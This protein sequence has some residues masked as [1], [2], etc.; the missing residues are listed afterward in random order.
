MTVLLGGIAYSP[1]IQSA[2]DFY[3]LSPTACAFT[4]DFG[5]SPSGFIIDGYK[6]HATDTGYV[7]R[8]GLSVNN[9][10]TTVTTWGIN[11]GHKAPS[12]LQDYYYRIH[13]SITALALGNVLSEQIF[14]VEIWNSWFVDD[15]LSDIGV[16]NLPDVNLTLPFATPKTFNP[17]EVITGTITVVTSGTPIIDGSYTLTFA[18]ESLSLPVIG[19]RIVVWPFSPAAQHTEQRQWLTDVLPAKQGETRYAMRD[20]ARTTLNYSYNFHSREDYTQARTLAKDV[21]NLALGL[22]LWTEVAKSINISAGA[23]TIYFDTTYL[24]LSINDPIILWQSYNSYEIV[25]IL[26]ITSTAVILKKG[27]IFGH[28]SCWVA[29]IGIFYTQGI[30]FSIAGGHKASAALS[31]MSTRTFTSPEWAEAVFDTLPVIPYSVVSGGLLSKYNRSQVTIDSG[32]GLVNTFDKE[33]YNRLH[34]TLQVKAENRK[35]LY[36]LRRAFDYFKGKYTAC[37][38]PSFTDDLIATEDVPNGV[39]GVRVL[40]E[41]FNA[42]TPGAIRI[43]GTGTIQC[44]LVTAITP[45]LAGTSYI[46]LDRVA[47]PGIANITKIEILSKVRFDSDTIEFSHKHLVSSDGK[48]AL[49]TLVKVPVL[50]IL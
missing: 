19:Q 14:Y 29:P 22:P 30:D 7:V 35:E 43:T 21:A 10:P 23:T 39:A 24:E 47:S 48:R 28:P 4:N 9:L 37:W 25:E 11:S 12:Y 36:T 34:G 45:G 18:T 5:T 6:P 26:L 41:G 38:L 16:N 50:E 49:F 17:L 44:F 15:N 46:T 33:G 31:G 8:G 27:T 42:H 3:R 20:T 1:S 2:Y 32:T 40:S 13:L